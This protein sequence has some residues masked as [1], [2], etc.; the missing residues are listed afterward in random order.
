M[1]GFCT[2][3]ANMV[4]ISRRGCATRPNGPITRRR[5]P[6]G[7]RACPDLG[8]PLLAH[9]VAGH[10]AGLKDDL[11]GSEGRIESK[12][13]LLGPIERTA[14]ATASCCRRMSPVPPA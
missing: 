4:L 11:L 10:H 6:S 1:P 7:P 2:T 13:A 5:A 8:G 9:V 14:E 3:S 12:S